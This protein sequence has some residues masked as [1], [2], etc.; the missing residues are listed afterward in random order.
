MALEACSRDRQY[1]VNAHV[2]A[3]LFFSF[4]KSVQTKGGGRGGKEKQTD[5]SR[6]A[7][8]SRAKKW[9]KER[10]KQVRPPR[11]LPA[12][13]GTQVRWGPE[14]ELRVCYSRWGARGYPAWLMLLLRGL[15]RPTRA[16][17]LFLSCSGSWCDCAG[18]TQAQGSA[19]CSSRERVRGARAWL[20]Y[21]ER[22]AVHCKLGTAA[23]FPGDGAFEIGGVEG[24][25]ENSEL[26]Q[27]GVPKNRGHFSMTGACNS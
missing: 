19:G 14:R 5:Q 16:W 1:S 6:Q 12:C 22:S 26:M 8:L 10:E 18:L 20:R 21:R 7:Q 9:L 15:P 25:R 2:A 27:N 13:R 17:C 11:A 4:T 24:V 3:V 23:T